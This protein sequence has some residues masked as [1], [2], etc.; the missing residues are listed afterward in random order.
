MKT[1]AEIDA[2]RQ[3]AILAHAPLLPKRACHY[4]AWEV[5]RLALWCCAKCAQ[6]YEKEKSELLSMKVVAPSP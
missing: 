4:C 2:E 1:L 5:P 3:A 6:S